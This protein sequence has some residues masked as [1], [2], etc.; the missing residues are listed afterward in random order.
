MRRYLI[1]W[2]AQISGESLVDANNK[3]E[4]EQKAYNNQDFD[5]DRFEEAYDW[6]I[7]KVE[8][9]PD[10]KSYDKGEK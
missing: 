6:T 3:E 2:S 8:E 9:A 1:T 10:R 4:A 7:D 5:F